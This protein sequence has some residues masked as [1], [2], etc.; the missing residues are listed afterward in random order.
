MA[1]IARRTLMQLAGG[2]AL[3][4]PALHTAQ[5]QAR[6]LVFGGSIPLSGGA[7]ETGLNVNNG[8]ATAVKF[9]NEQGGVDIAV[10]K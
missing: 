9:L 1:R 2:T 4:M 8:Y 7:A 10:M 6:K 5:A 3:A